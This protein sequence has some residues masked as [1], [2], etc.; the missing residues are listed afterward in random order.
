MGIEQSGPKEEHLLKM[1][2]YRKQRIEKLGY[3]PAESNN[4]EE[5]RQLDPKI[6]AAFEEV[7]GAESNIEEESNQV[8]FYGDYSKTGMYFVEY[9]YGS[10]EKLHLTVNTDFGCEQEPEDSIKD[11][12]RMIKIREQMVALG[13]QASKG[14]I[15][16]AY[17]LYL[18]KE[19]KKEELSDDLKRIKQALEL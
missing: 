1:E 19:V 15:G 7:F 3:D 14:V 4:E 9:G 11:L 18:E 8:T 12:Q 2:Q 6:I 17:D 16:S 13:Y 10:G 5:D